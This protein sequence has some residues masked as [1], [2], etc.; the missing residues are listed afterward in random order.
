MLLVHGV[1]RVTDVEELSNIVI[2]SR[3]GQPIYLKNVADVAVG[4]DGPLRRGSVTFDGRGEAM[5]G[6]GFLTTGENS[7][8]V[9]T[10]MREKLKDVETRLPRDVEVVPVYDRTELID[11]VVATAKKNLFEGG[12]LVVA[13]FLRSW[14]ICV[15]RS[16][17]H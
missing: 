9:T 3:D 10:G 13:V 7:H 11:V 16:S 4:D 8:T 6:L 1:G 2:A 15:P 12:L 5:L 17:S 14:E